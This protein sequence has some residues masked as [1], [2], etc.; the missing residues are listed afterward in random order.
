MVSFQ[1][2]LLLAATA[3]S[4]TALPSTSAKPPGKPPH[5][6]PCATVRCGFNTVCEAV[7]GKARCVPGTKCGPTMCGAG[8][9]CCNASCGIC[10]PPD[11]A[12]IQIFCESPS[13]F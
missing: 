8:Q 6:D 13:K 11:G 1:T 12:C 9:V 4:A 3:L 5:H 2:L 10:T 7:K